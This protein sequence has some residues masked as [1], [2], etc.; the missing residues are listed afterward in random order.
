MLVASTLPLATGTLELAAL[1]AHIGLGMAVFVTRGGTKVFH[2][3]A[4]CSLT[5]QQHGSLTKRRHKG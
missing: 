5:T 3:I 1:A 4:C 2:G